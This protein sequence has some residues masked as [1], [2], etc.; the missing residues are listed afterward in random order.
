MH[1]V[2]QHIKC[3]WLSVPIVWTKKRAACMRP[4][5]GWKHKWQ[6]IR[7]NGTQYSWN[8]RWCTCLTELV[9]SIQFIF[10]TRAVLRWVRSSDVLIICFLFRSLGS[11]TVRSHPLSLSCGTSWSV[12]CLLPQQ[13]LSCFVMKRNVCWI[14]GVIS[15]SMQPL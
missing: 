5:S 4:C 2:E 11:Q 8:S 13:A 10:N 9:R 15:R 12:I 7:R 6:K 3:H 1:G 14:H